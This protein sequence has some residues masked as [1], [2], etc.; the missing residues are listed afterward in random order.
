MEEK[1]RQRNRIFVPNNLIAPRLCPELAKEIGLNE[2]ILLLQIDF[3]IS[4]SNAEEHEGRS[5]TYQSTRAIQETFLYW[6]LMTINRAINSLIA[7]HLII[8]RNFNKK[9]YDKTRW[10]AIDFEGCQK[11][12]SVAI[13]EGVGTRSNQD[14]TST[15]QNGTRT[16]HFDTTIPETSSENSSKKGEQPHPPVLQGEEKINFEDGNDI[17]QS[18]DCPYGVLDK[19]DS[20]FSFTPKKQSNADI[21]G[22]S[23]FSIKEEI[24]ALVERA[25]P[26]DKASRPRL[27]K[28][29]VTLIDEGEKTIE[30]I[31]KHI[32]WRKSEGKDWAFL[33]TDFE[34]DDIRMKR[35]KHG[36]SNGRGASWDS[37]R[38]A[39]VEP[40]YV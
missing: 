14:D 13:R 5:W 27:R 24:D 23:G 22:S 28:Q 18:E 17:I 34:A 20:C 21:S 30:E 4:I 36:D 15:N 19:I 31:E 33:L 6:S 35:P 1:D 37:Q 29:V 12:M 9:K 32:A 26:Y 3:W 38:K 10:F 8:V 11:L 40:Y 25:L 2:S 7:K 16:D 39:W